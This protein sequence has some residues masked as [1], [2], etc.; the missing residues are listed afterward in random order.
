MMNWGSGLIQ[1]TVVEGVENKKLIP[2]VGP[3][4]LLIY[5]L[6]EDDVSDGWR[7]YCLV[8]MSRNTHCLSAIRGMD[9]DGRR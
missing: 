1:V 5:C 9:G 2:S 4:A 7:R 8:I 3:S 6:V